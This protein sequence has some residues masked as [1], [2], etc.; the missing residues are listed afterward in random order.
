MPLIIVA[1]GVATPGSRTAKPVSLLD[2]YPTLTELAELPTPQ[3]VEGTSLVPLLRDPNA[4]WEHAA[5]TNN[6]YREHSVRGERY[7]YIRY[8][9]ATE[10]LYDMVSDPHEWNNLADDPRFSHVIERLTAWLP[11]TNATSLGP[12]PKSRPSR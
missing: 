1:P 6:G 11:L 12:D 9:D 7:R 5:V 10:E 3:H 8:A 2:I 4:T